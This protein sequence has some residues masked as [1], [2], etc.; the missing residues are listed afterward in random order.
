MTNKQELGQKGEKLAA[1][2]IRSKGYQ[3][4]ETNYR[5]KRNEIDIIAK[6]SDLLVFIEVKARSYTTFGDP[7]QAVTS[8]KAK[9]IFEAA[10]NYIFENNWNG[11]IRF[12][13][14]SILFGRDPEII[15]FE[16]AIC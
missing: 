11:N 12:D 2:F 16:D 9:H 10:E 15:H 1:E 7:E 13:I 8:N 6:N 4:V 5:Y 14:I 3:I